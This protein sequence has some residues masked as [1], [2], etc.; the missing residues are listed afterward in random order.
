MIAAVVARNF[1]S[2]MVHSNQSVFF[3]G[4]EADAK[5]AV[6]VFVY[7]LNFADSAYSK[8]FQNRPVTSQAA[9]DWKNGFIVGLHTAFNSRAGYELM[10][11]VPQKV[12][13]T[14]EKLN[15][16]KMDMSNSNRPKTIAGAFTDGFRRGRESMDK[17][18]IEAK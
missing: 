16:K 4:F 12:I 14:F 15:T 7:L 10:I 1:R 8:Y 5:A 9:S 11:T 6:E 13:E 17:R 2:K 3:I 18:E